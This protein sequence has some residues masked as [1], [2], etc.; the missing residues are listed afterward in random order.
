M[1]AQV[2]HELDVRELLPHDGPMVLVDRILRHGPSETACVVDVSTQDLFRDRD[3]SIPLWVGLEYM[4]QCS[5]VHAAA[6]AV[7]T[8]VGEPGHSIL[9]VSVR[10]L[11]FHCDRFRGRWI[12]AVAHRRAGRGAVAEFDCMLRDLETGELL[13]EGRLYGLRRRS[14]EA[15]FDA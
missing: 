7:G 9:L 14:G 10:N 3:G 6:A 4:A 13:A 2:D 11:R 12:E 5:A 15:A 1:S 8:G